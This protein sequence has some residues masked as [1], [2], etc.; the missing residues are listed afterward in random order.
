MY[1]LFSRYFDRVSS[2]FDK[3]HS[4]KPQVAMLIDLNFIISTFYP[5]IV[6]QLKKRFERPV[7]ELET[8]EESSLKLLGR[9][10]KKFAGDRMTRLFGK[11]GWDFANMD[12]SKVC[13]C[14]G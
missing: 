2:S 12:Y 13:L 9:V 5:T 3:E 4:I 10:R 7:V 6:A 8:L 14:H 11:D 1:T